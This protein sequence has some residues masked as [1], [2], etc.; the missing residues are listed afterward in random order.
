MASFGQP[1]GH[2]SFP[3]LFARPRS[4]VSEIVEI[5]SNR[6]KGD[7]TPN[8]QHFAPATPLFAFPLPVR[9]R[10]QP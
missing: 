8:W 1:P 4:A 9:L 3:M 2:P 7:F 5:S 10:P 6:K